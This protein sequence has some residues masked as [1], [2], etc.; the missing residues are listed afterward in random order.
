MIIALA[1]V[2]KYRKP[3]TINKHSIFIGAPPG[4]GGAEGNVR[5]LLTKTPPVPS[6]GP[7][8]RRGISFERFPLIDIVLE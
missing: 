5:L 8:K 6:V 2:S 7:R 3:K 4:Q 1:T